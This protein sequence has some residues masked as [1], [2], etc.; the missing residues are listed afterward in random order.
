MN[1]QR[2]IYRSAAASPQTPSKSLRAWGV[3][4]LLGYMLVGCSVQPTGVVPAST[5]SQTVQDQSPAPSERQAYEPSAR[6]N[7]AHLS[8]AA[9]ELVAKAKRY[10]SSGDSAS[11]LRYLERAQRISPRAPQVYIA[12][13]EAKVQQGQI[14]QARQ[15]AN[16][17]LSLVGGDEDLKQTIQMFIDQL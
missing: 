11:A 5:E 10:S 3:S 1:N 15:L 13:A 8:P 4:V 16:K 14:N 17:A 2:N 9:Q 7:T 6:T 12:M